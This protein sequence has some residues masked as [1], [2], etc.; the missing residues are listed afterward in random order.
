MR[1]RETRLSGIVS[2]VA[3]G[4]SVLMVPTPLEWIPIPVLYG[5]FLYL[6]VTG[7]A[8]NQ[9]WE[10]ILLVCPVLFCAPTT[11]DCTMCQRRQAQSLSTD[12]IISTILPCL[13]FHCHWHQNSSIVRF[14]YPYPMHHFD[15]IPIVILFIIIGI[16]LL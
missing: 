2:H 11:A 1:V 14:P 13:S 8:G 3:I 9:F 12:M 10:R 4:L 7:L 6:A 16:F 15:I 5:V